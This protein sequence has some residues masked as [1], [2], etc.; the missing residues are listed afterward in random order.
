MQ[1]CPSVKQFITYEKEMNEGFAK[2]A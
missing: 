1:E 2:T